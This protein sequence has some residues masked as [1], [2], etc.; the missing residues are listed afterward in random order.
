[1]AKF[2]SSQSSQGS[3]SS[4]D[5][6]RQGLI[7]GLGSIFQRWKIHDGNKKAVEHPQATV[8]IFPEN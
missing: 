7:W 3:Q 2:P 8:I 1:M 6:R 5:L 4:Q